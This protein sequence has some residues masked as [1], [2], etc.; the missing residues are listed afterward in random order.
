MINTSTAYREAVTGTTRRT[1]LQIVANLSDPD[2]VFTGVASNNQAGISVPGQVVNYTKE[3]SRYATLERN[4]WLLDGSFNLFNDNLT[5]NGEE[6]GGISEAH[7]A[8][9]GTLSPAIWFE[10]QFANIEILQMCNLYFNVDPNDGIP[11]DFTVTFYQN[12]TLLD[13]VTVTG[14][15][16]TEVVLTGFTVYMPDALRVTVTKWSL[17]MR[18]V[19]FA[20]IFPGAFIRWTGSDVA[21]LRV[22]M[23]ADPSCVNLP[24]ATCALTLD[25]TDRLFE[26][27]NK[28]GIFQS[29]QER[30]PVSVEIGVM[31][32]GQYE[33]HSVGT[34]YQYN[35]GWKTSDN[36]LTIKWDMVDIIGLLTDREFIPP[37]TLP[38]TLTGWVSAVLSTLGGSFGSRYTIDPDYA[39]LTLTATTEAVTG[40]KCGAM[41]LNLCMA[42]G[43]WPRMDQSTGRLAI[44][45]LWSQGNKIDL[46]NMESYPTIQA[47]ADIAQVIFTLNDGQDTQV[48][49]GGTDFASSQSV[50]VQNPFL[51]TSAA[52]LEAARNI[53]SVYGGNAYSIVGR[54]DPSNEVGD[55]MTLELDERTAT[56][57]RLISQTFSYSRQ[58]LSGC[59]MKLIQSAGAL[60][61]EERVE[62]IEDGTWTVPTGVTV[63]NLVLVGG[64]NGG[65]NGTNGSFFRAGTDG[66]DGI[67]GLVYKTTINVTAGTSYAV[68]IGHGGAENGGE[69]T[70]TTFGSFSSENGAWYLPSFTDISSGKAYGRSGAYDPPLHTG[71]GGKG[72]KG[73]TK[74]EEHKVEKR[75]KDEDGFV[76][77]KT[78]WVTDV[79]P[80]KGTPGYAGSDGAVIIYYDKG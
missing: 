6:V 60:M 44:E 37:S 9:D 21:D 45:P 43:T 10:V 63:I 24:Y 80:G 57:A 55:V 52:A 5:A 25:N 34:F 16:Q 56:T 17:P 50:S 46:D 51:Q 1:A 15:T 70:A 68:T 33:Y 67:G 74:G 59:A 78:R 79:E 14:N 13:T 12:G 64:G 73:G 23:T 22:D 69:G 76:H 49:V 3:L 2:L 28:E 27:R 77:V 26:P 72:G 47:N 58:V 62:L 38:T 30:Q 19:R 4:R 20:E 7:S 54:G 40:L 71:D 66:E 41:L 53:V 8:E 75:Y 39:G 48:A 31:V 29:L 11:E 65:V 36:G 42:T 18:R 32:E 35:A 61:Y